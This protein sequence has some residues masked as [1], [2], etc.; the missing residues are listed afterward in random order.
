MEAIAPMRISF[1]GG[2][3]DVEP[4]CSKYGGLVL[5]AAIQIYAHA[6]HPATKHELSELEKTILRYFGVKGGLK[7]VNEIPHMSGLGGSAACFVAGIKAMKPSMGQPSIAQL[8][9]HLERNVMKV[10]GGKQDQYCAA[11]GGLLYMELDKNVATQISVPKGLEDLLLLV[12]MGERKNRGQDI[13]KDQMGNMVKNI[14]SFHRQKYL[15]NEMM[16]FCHHNNLTGFGKALNNAWETKLEFSP[17]I[18]DDNIRGFYKNCLRD[19]AIGGKLTGAGGGGYMLLMEHP[20][21]KG[22]LRMNLANSGIKYI[23]VKFDMEGVRIKK[24]G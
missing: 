4:Y 19:G 24:G 11:F 22:V 10:A 8:A 12:Y 18:A 1:A 5:S 2:G 3:T 16:Y 15:A 23:N 20:E 17:L 6:T 14:E 13:I 21:K 7:I 9:I